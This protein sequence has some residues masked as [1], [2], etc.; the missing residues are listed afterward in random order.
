MLIQ[1]DIS[2][3]FTAYLLIWLA[4]ILTT[5]NCLDNG[6]AL[7]PPMGWCTWNYYGRNFNESVFYSAVKIMNETGM[8]K[9]GYEYINVDGGWWAHEN[10]SLVRNATGFT[11]YSHTKYPNGIVNVIKYIHGNGYKYGH[12]TDAGTHACD[13]D[14][15]MSENY[16][17]QDIGLFLSWNIDMIKIDSCGVVGNITENI[18]EFSPLLNKSYALNGKNVLFSNCHNMCMNDQSKS[19]DIPKVWGQ[20][21][22]DNFNM[23][24][25]SDDIK[26]EWHK[27]LSTIGNINIYIL[28]M[29][30]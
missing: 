23:W 20:W 12:Y 30:V 5:V 14:K 2:I 17:E 10:N 16:K 9:A 4:T 29:H 1:L 19:N 15:N 22:A 7:K 28:D 6:V 24:R 13:G 25:I 21:C 26:P 8:R 18:L 27:M 3:A 11:T